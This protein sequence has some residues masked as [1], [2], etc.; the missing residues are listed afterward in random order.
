MIQPGVQWKVIRLFSKKYF[1]FL[2]SVV[3]ELIAADI[4]L[5]VQWN[6]IDYMDQ[7][8]DFTYDPVNYHDLPLLV[9]K[10]HSQ[11]KKYV[12][13]LDPAIPINVDKSYT[14]LSDGL[15]MNIFIKDQNQPVEGAVW[16]GPTYFPDFTHPNA[17]KYWTKQIAKLYNSGVKFDG[18]WIDM[19]EPSN[20]V[21]GTKE[22]SCPI[23]QYNQPPWQPTIQNGLLRQQ[24]LC[25]SFEQFES[26]HY[27]LHN[28][29]GLH[30]SKATYSALQ[31]LQVGKFKKSQNQL[32]LSL[33]ND[34]LFCLAVQV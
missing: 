1:R 26:S 18:L 30:E 11:S 29:Y 3:D 5:E 16:P 22:N 4:P 19:N 17:T 6:D 20:F 12:A 24:T 7:K 8:R 25:P 28:L 2:I 34:H 21:S 33:T 14:P 10:L 9:D 32:L 23:H 31:S 15:E 27:N 13:I